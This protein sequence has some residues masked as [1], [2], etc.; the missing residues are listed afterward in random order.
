MNFAAKRIRITIPFGGANASRYFE[1]LNLVG[2]T[3]K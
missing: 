2:D 1:N 3:A